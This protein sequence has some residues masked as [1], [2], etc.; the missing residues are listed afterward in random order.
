[1]SRFLLTCFSV[2]ISVLVLAQQ[3]DSLLIRKIADDVLVNGKAYDN[4]HELTKTVGPRLSGSPQ[5][6]QAEQWAKK[7]LQAAG[8]D[9]VWLQEC[10]IPHW[11]R[12]GK[13]AAE[14]IINGKRTPM[15]VLA[16]GNS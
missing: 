9:K 16:L 12:G 15:N 4:L 2:F 8:A 5:T 13:E 11:V 10:I 7:T 1:M 3:E 6:Y 14:M